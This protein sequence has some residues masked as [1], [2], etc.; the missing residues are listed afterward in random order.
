MIDE[1][2]LQEFNIV[3]WQLP[4]IYIVDLPITTGDVPLLI[5]LVY[6][7]VDEVTTGHTCMEYLETSHPRM[8]PWSH[9]EPAVRRHR[10]YE[11]I[12]A[13]YFAG[14]Q[15]AH[16]AEQG[17]V[18]TIFGPPGLLL[19]GHSAARITDWPS[20]EVSFL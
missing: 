16:F 11:C 17:V 20:L 12:Q 1:V 15:L 18:Q 2:T 10:G 9:V 7:G 5:M 6:Q 13:P 8:S 4:F 3:C 19:Y 14:A